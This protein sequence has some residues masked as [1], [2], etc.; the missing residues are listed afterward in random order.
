MRILVIG[1]AGFIGANVAQHYL[2]KKFHVGILDN[3]SRAGSKA[4]LNWLKNRFKKRLNVVRADIRYDKKKLKKL[5][6]KVRFNWIYFFFNV[7]STNF[8][9][10]SVQSRVY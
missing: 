9:A 7:M 2:K 3:F 8:P 4:N 6:D 1:G 5:I 10:N